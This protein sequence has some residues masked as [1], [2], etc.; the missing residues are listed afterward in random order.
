MIEDREVKNIANAALVIHYSTRDKTLREILGEMDRFEK[1]RQRWAY[2]R[3]RIDRM[4][5]DN[6][7][8][9]KSTY[10]KRGM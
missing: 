4:I 10:E 2:L 6:E 8:M 5:L 7:L 1:D 3:S 9:R